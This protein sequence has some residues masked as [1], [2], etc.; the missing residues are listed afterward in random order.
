MHRSV[1]S[2]VRPSIS[3]LRTHRASI[4]FNLC[5]RQARSNFR[6]S[7]FF[8]RAMSTSNSSTDTSTAKAEVSIAREFLTFINQSPSQFHATAAAC[9]L[10][11]QAGFT[12][13]RERDDWTGKLKPNGSYFYTRNQS[14]LVAFTLPSTYT[15]AYSHSATASS[16]TP[17]SHPFIILAAHTDS[18]VLKVK[19]VSKVN[20][21]GYLQV[22][23]ECYGG[24]LWH[25]W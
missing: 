12:R 1:C 20:K 25:T 22:G 24:G 4:P 7:R 5:H 2:I 18:P 13:L 16:A 17:S 8:S 21:V 23:V 10:L 19:P 9:Q 15:P 14:S 3:P 6:L 11:E